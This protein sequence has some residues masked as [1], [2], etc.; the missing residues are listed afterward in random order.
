MKGT[1]KNIAL[2][3]AAMAFAVPTPA[4]AQ[5]LSEDAY[6]SPDV[7]VLTDNPGDD[8]SNT[9]GNDSNS[10]R[11]AK[12]VTAAK[13]NSDGGSLPFT[14]LDLGLLGVAGAGLVALGFGMRRLTRSPDVA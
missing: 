2:A 3:V 4:L 11:D 9:N 8:N 12:P 5:E 7:E 1:K 6:N 13:S 10:S 14:G